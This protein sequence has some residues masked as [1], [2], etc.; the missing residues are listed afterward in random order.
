[1]VILKIKNHLTRIKTWVLMFPMPF[2]EIHRW[3]DSLLNAVPTEELIRFQEFKSRGGI[4]PRSL[5]SDYQKFFEDG[6]SDLLASVEEVE[7]KN[8]I[9]LGGYLGDSVDRYLKLGA[10]AIDVFEPVPEYFEKLDHRFRSM[11]QINLIDKAAWVRNETLE[12]W[13]DNDGTGFSGRTGTPIT[14][15]AIRLSTWLS[16]QEEGKK[17]FIE[18]NI[19]GSEYALLE[20]L[21]STGM[22]NRLETILVQFHNFS[23]ESETQR[24]NLRSELANSHFELMNYKWVWEKWALK[25]SVNKH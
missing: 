21:M 4:Y 12:F 24:T 10:R 7:G 5:G 23:P 13:L 11:S 6:G 25:A 14:V 17:Y 15:D 18:I 16:R 20:D 3:H 22:A 1:M 19:E 8:V 9:V 2:R